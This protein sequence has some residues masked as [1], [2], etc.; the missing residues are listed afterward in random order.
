MMMVCL[1]HIDILVNYVRRLLEKLKGK[2]IKNLFIKRIKNI[3]S[4]EKKNLKNTEKLTNFQ[5]KK[6]KSIDQN[7][8]IK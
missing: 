1:G 5:K 3:I 6:G 7:T 2:T 8:R 4:K